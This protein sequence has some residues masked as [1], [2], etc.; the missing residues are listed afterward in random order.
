MLLILAALLKKRRYFVKKALP[1]NWAEVFI[2]EFQSSYQVLGFFNRAWANPCLIPSRQC[3][4]CKARASGKWGRAGGARN[5][6]ND[7]L[8]TSSSRLLPHWLPVLARAPPSL[9]IEKPVEEAGQSCQI[10]A[11]EFLQRI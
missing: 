10:I 5:E 1:G 6:G 4:K 8:A 11:P 9:I 3:K 7:A 2:W